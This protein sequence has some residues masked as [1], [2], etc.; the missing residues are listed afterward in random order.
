MSIKLIVNN[1]VTQARIGELRGAR[2]EELAWELDAPGGASISINP[3]NKTAS[4]IAVNKTEIQIWIDDVL[5]HWVIPR[6]CTGDH[7]RITFQCVGLLDH[8]S[9]RRIRSTLTYTSIDQFNIGWN[10]VNYA[11]TGTNRNR[12]ITAA[13]YTPSGYTRSRQYERNEAKS[14][15]ECLQEFPNLENGF[16]FE[17]VV[18]GDGRREWTPYF[19]Q[20][21][22][23]K[24]HL[25]LEW[26]RNIVGLNY[27]EAGQNQG[28]KVWATGG[29]SGDVRFEENYEDVALSA[30]YGQMER[31]V[32]EGSQQ[33]V[34]WLADRA[35]EEVGTF[36]LPTKLPELVVN[37]D[38]GVLETG[39]VVPVKVQHGYIDMV[40]NYR[41]SRLRRLK[42]GRLGLS[43]Y[44]VAS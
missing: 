24:P 17:I 7:K 29:S 37:Y 30:E 42:T 8:M 9:Y 23:Y 1:A 41:I 20:K 35:A 22:S 40:G 36:G 18:F 13:T 16:D 15:I 19:P 2:V 39:D 38:L 4:F 11:Q 33:D 12:F 26:G 32:S 43:F 5:R 14:I 28:T 34:D 27:N 21:G 10:L 44:E 6:G 3:L 25:A 31:M